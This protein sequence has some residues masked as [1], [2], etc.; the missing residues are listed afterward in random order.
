[1]FDAALEKRCECSE[2]PVSVQGFESFRLFKPIGVRSF[3][4][5]K[6]VQRLTRCATKVTHWPALK[7][8]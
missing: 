4:G 8:C 2:L 7:R 1:M 6:L 5:W 3:G